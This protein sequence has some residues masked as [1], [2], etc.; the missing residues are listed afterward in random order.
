MFTLKTPQFVCSLALGLI[1][2][3]S[4]VDDS[5]TLETH[6]RSLQEQSAKSET[7][8]EDGPFVGVE[9][10]YPNLRFNR[11][12]YLT[13]SGDG[14]GRMFVVEQDGVIRVFPGTANRDDMDRIKDS[15][16]FLDIREKVSR[17]G[18]EEGLIGLAFHPDYAENGQFFVHYSLKTN[19]RDENGRP[20]VAS[21][22]ISRYSVSTSNRDRADPDSEDVIMT[23]SQPYANHNGGMIEFG[24]DGFLYVT[25]GDGG[26]ANDPHGNAQN[27]ATLLGSIIRID[28][29]KTSDGRN[30]S[31]PDDNPFLN[32]EGAA[33]EQ[34]AI[35]LRNVWR[36]SF[37][38]A[39]GTLIAADVGQNKIEEV[40]IIER[41]GNYGWNRF[42]ANETFNADTQLVH[43]E[44]VQPVA[45]YGRSWGISITGGYVYRGEDHPEL[46]GKYFYGDYASGNLWAMAR[47]EKGVYRNELVRR[48]GRSIASFG[49][50]DRGELYLLSFDGG[51]YR[52]VT[53]DQP[54]DTFGDWPSKLSETG[55]YA[56]IQ[57]QE[58]AADL[59]PY[60]VNAPFWSDGADK[61]RYIRLPE[62]EKMTYA[63]S[64]SWNVPIGTVIV[65]NFH[66]EHLRNKQTQ[67]ETRLIKRT[68]E[69]W[70]SAT[71]VWNLNG[72]DAELLPA[73]KQFE[74]YQRGQRRW[75]VRSWH[76][77]SASECASCHTDAAGYVLGLKTAQLNSDV[78]GKN[79]LV[80]WS[81]QGIVDLPEDFDPVSAARFCDPLA[82]DGTLEDR[83]RVYLDVNCAM[84]HQ[85]NGPGNANIDL[86][87]TTDLEKT[88]MIG[89]PPAQ[90]EMGIA[91]ALIVAPGAP[92]RSLLLHRVETLGAGRMPT[93]GSNLVDEKAS[94]LLKQWIESLDK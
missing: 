14:S 91:N 18:N 78:D 32:V 67:F 93:I 16:V 75:E 40:N 79:Q 7:T 29:D 84:C 76:A 10:V 39:D 43:G 27:M 56:N 92:E 72:S 54:E 25:F 83:A 37:D 53:T 21:N 51:V 8:Q 13:G 9:R 71:Y 61:G 31:I 22:V 65:K 49:E 62:G 50:D 1:V 52:V 58:L 2:A 36:F 41:G 90:G 30:Y 69:G 20:K 48:T 94:E 17:R 3:A 4:M 77:P 70:Q 82:K 57:D 33:P 24:P 55:L 81:R 73:G 28:V 19:E 11:P 34:W 74:V 15:A 66:G 59:I 42:E 44:H 87:Y 38:R 12:V 86:R 45:M 5:S 68:P 35:G 60:K 23:Q 88:R 26:S 85:P 64:G 6:P 63:E 46:Q 47:D 80:R 89:E